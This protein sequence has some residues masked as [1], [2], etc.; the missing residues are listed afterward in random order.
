MKR[1]FQL[2]F[3]LA[4]FSLGFSQN[5][6]PIA[7]K[8]HAAQS[9]KKTF[10]KYD[11]F[12]AD[13]SAQ[14][15][16][17]YSAAAEGIT[18]MQLNKAEVQKINSERPEALEMSFPFE[19]KNITVELVKNNLFTQDFK[20]NTE[21]GFF[22]YKPGVYYHGIV[23]N[24]NKSLVA[25]SFFNDEVIGISSVENVGNIVL[26]KVTDGEDY[27]SYND[28]KLTEKNPFVCGADE[29][30]ENQKANIPSFDPSK[31]TTKMT[32]NCVRIY[33]EVGYSLYTRNGSNVTT[34]T[35]WT[36]ALHNNVDTLYE[37]DQI[38]VALSQVFVWTTQDPYSGE[39]LD[40]LNQFK[41]NRTSFNGDVA[42]LLRWPNTTSIA[43][44]N[45]L[46]TTSKYSYCGLNMQSI[47]VPTYSWNIEAMT[48]E[49][50]HNLGSPHTHAC[51]WNG[52]DTA[53][54]GCGPSAGYSEGC[55]APLPTNGGT[56]M[57]YCHLTNVGINFANGFGPQPGT[58]IRNT[59][60]SK[61]CLGMDCVTSCDVTITGMTVSNVTQTSVTATI[62]DAVATSWKYKLVKMDGTVVDSGVTTNKVLNFTN[63]TPG[64]Y[65]K[66][67]VG[68]EC[69]GPQA[70]AYEQLLMTDANWCSGI[71]FTDTGGEN[72]NYTDGEVIVKTFYPSNSGDKLKMTFTQFETEEGYDFMNIYNGPSTG[73]PR[74]QGGTQVSGNN[75]PGPFTS[76]HA[77]G[78]ITV[79]FISDQGLTAAGWNA[80][81][82]CLSLGTGENITSSG[83][84]ISR[85]SAKGIFSITSKEKIVSYEIF[86]ASGKLIKKSGNLNVAETNVDL[87]ASPVG[88]YVV[89]VTTATETV[90]KKI[91]R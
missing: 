73:S 68:T 11:L 17:K 77:T 79:R 89:S 82:E 18:V 55:D 78:A 13:N 38:N 10:V 66:V 15:Q 44:L 25:I 83:V 21:K 60:N 45:S 76:T 56:I 20:V 34:T 65:Y 26:G 41:N 80:T 48:H 71:N 81:I 72:G 67:A 43:F 91:L 70:F 28:Q 40:I 84:N 33:Y 27:V 30:P 8:V 53:I 24:D 35:N 19:G 31:L 85:T 1:I 3:S 14:K 32:D 23:K 42:Q 54:D 47:N 6:K 5:L 63:L 50:G 69:S 90:T 52:N 9:A 16:A 39:P 7:E 46:C 57:S 88:T 51:K 58:L 2:C 75:I 37:N 4:F 87:S 64:T 49:L 62:I 29:V 61:G 59:V 12:T 36:T 22:N 86:D 74:F